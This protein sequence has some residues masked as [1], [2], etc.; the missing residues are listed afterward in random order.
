MCPVFAKVYSQQF[1]GQLLVSVTTSSNCS[2]IVILHASPFFLGAYISETSEKHLRKRIGM[3]QSVLVSFGYIIS[4][5]L[6]YFIGWRLTCH[7]MV[8]ITSLSSAFTLILPETPYWLIEKG[9]HE[10]AL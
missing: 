8:V 10:E 9:R 7:V 6:G 1:H 2:H 3:C 5:S 4:H